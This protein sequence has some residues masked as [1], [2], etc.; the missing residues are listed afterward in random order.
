MS[1]TYFIF[2]KSNQAF[3]GIKDRW[4]SI[5]EQRTTGVCLLVTTIILL[6]YAV[7][8]GNWEDYTQQFFHRSFVHLISLDFC[9]MC[10]IFP[11]TSLFDDDM[12]RRGI[13]D[14]RIFW[15]VALFPL[16]GSLLYLCLRPSLPETFLKECNTTVNSPL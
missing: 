1:S 5:I 11:V 8:A 7:L 3:Y 12:A 15:I 6:S 9:L 10:L 16:F 4:L 13:K 2:R 14:T